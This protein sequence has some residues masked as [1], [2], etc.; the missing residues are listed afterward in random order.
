MTK[1]E[2]DKALWIMGAT[3]WTLHNV[4]GIPTVLRDKM[5]A[6]CPLLAGNKDESAADE[7]TETVAT[8][9]D[10]VKE[11]KPIETFGLTPARDEQHTYND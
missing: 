10:P 4:V 8:I 6:A 5:L 1:I 3:G 7:C 2:R 11:L 9:I